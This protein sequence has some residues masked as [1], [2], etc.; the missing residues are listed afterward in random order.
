MGFGVGSLGFRVWVFGVLS[1][2][3][4]AWAWAW[5]VEA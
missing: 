5:R 4:C 1:L 3:A 2:G